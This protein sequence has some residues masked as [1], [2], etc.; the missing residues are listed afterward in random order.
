MQ[1]HRSIFSLL[2]GNM[3]A[4]TLSWVATFFASL[5][6]SV[7]TTYVFRYDFVSNI[8]G[9]LA[10]QIG[11]IMLNLL[12]LLWSV[13]LSRK[14]L[15][16]IGAPV[17]VF[18]I[19]LNAA[20][21]CLL[22]YAPM[23][24]FKLFAQFNGVEISGSGA[25]LYDMVGSYSDQLGRLFIDTSGVDVAALREQYGNVIERGLGIFSALIALLYLRSFFSGRKA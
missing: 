23:M 2:G 14:Y 13:V 16:G 25:P 8:D 1:A 11:V 3:K 18:W 6:N 21:I 10:S 5:V 4:Y 17:N 9:A 12:Y 22:I 7:W 15:F 19:L 20:F 24:A